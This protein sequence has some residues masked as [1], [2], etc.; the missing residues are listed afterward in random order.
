GPKA[1]LTYTNPYL[2]NWAADKLYR[3][4]PSPD[5]L[6]LLKRVS[7]SVERYT[8]WMED[9]KNGRVILDKNG[10]V[11][12]FNG[13]ALGSGLDNSRLNVGNANELAGHQRGFVDF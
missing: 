4:N 12:G 6:A 9:P 13:S 11:I 1:N 7:N 2:L 5:N 3:Y 8:A 10:N